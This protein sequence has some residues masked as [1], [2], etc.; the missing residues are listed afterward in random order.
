MAT[1]NPSERCNDGNNKA[2]AAIS[3]GWPD[4]RAPTT[5]ENR[6]CALPTLPAH[7]TLPPSLPP[8]STHPH[9]HGSNNNQLGSSLDRRVMSGPCTHH[10]QTTNNERRRSFLHTNDAPTSL[11]ATQ[12]W[13]AIDPSSFGRHSLVYGDTAWFLLHR[14]INVLGIYYECNIHFISI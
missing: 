14:N 3:P 11:A 13:T 9:P 1:F 12:H 5:K 2:G 4:T 10:E 7:G 8:S 6:V